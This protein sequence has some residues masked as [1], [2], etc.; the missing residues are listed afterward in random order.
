[1]TTLPV[2]LSI[3]HGG[4]EIPEELK[5]RICID[6]FD[7]FEDGDAFTRE[8]YHLQNRVTD[9]VTTDIARAFVDLNRSTDDMPPQNPDGLIKSM[10]CF[11]KPIY[12]QGKEPDNSLTN[13]LIER[14]Y[15]PYHSRIREIIKQET[16]LL[17]LDCHSMAAEAPAIAPDAGKKQKRPLLCLGN[18]HEKSCPGKTVEKLSECF[19]RAFSLKRSEVSI[20][21]PFSG[22]YITR[23]YGR[24]PVPWVQVELNR[25]LYLASPWFDSSNLQ[26]DKNRLQQLNHQFENAL[27]LFFGMESTSTGK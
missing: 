3:P 21:R 1:M 12:I 24:N 15:L 23:A 10:T 14:Y 9:V 18:V 27:R 11:Q 16:I 13:T 19:C 20:N 5:E 2:L 26:I 6:P 4:T 8:I 25:S 22:G 17:A 7:L